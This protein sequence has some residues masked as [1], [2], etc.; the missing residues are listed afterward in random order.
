[1][2]LADQY[3]NDKV[4]T[5]TPAQLSGMLFD[6]AVGSLRGAIRAMEAEQWQPAV[7]RSVKAQRI[8]FELRDCLNHEV[9]GE[10]AGN[11]HELYTWSYLTL[12]RSTQDKDVQAVKD[13]LG[14]MEPLA[15]GWR[16]AV[17]GSAPQP[18]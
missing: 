13:V 15:T 18:A 14:V 4:A 2:A 16:E 11:L 12:S 6:G 7:A 9:G 1:M 3:L 5:A 8:I 17:L 10:I